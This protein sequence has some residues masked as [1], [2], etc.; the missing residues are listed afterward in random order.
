MVHEKNLG[1][2]AFFDDLNTLRFGYGLCR[3]GVVANFRPA[4]DMS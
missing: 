3:V 1:G 4:F 2:S